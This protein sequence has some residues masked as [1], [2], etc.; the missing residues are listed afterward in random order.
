MIMR[1]NNESFEAMYCRKENVLTQ[2]I[3]PKKIYF[4]VHFCKKKCTRVCNIFFICTF[5]NCCNLIESIMAATHSRRLI[6]CCFALII[7]V[8]LL[9]GCVSLF[10]VD[11]FVIGSAG[12]K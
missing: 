8:F 3:L 7:L 4:S 1:L 10:P 12:R 9:S 11:T 6:D 2:R 5:R